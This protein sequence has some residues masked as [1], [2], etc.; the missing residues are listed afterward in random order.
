MPERH[1]RLT[2][3]YFQKPINAHSIARL[4]A[5][6][7]CPPA[8]VA[9]LASTKRLL[10]GHGLTGPAMPSANVCN[11]NTP[12]SSPF[13]NTQNP[14]NPY[15]RISPTTVIVLHHS[16]PSSI[17]HFSW[18]PTVILWLLTWGNDEDLHPHHNIAIVNMRISPAQ[19]FCSPAARI[20]MYEVRFQS[21]FLV[22]SASMSVAS[23]H[24]LTVSALFL[25]DCGTIADL[26]VPHV[27]LM[28]DLSSFLFLFG[29][30]R[31]LFL[32]FVIV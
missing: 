30:L 7:S 18:H 20:F 21:C 8:P 12:P 15:C 24:I 26:Y 19:S 16:P 5:H 22:H 13:P 4:H 17:L 3:S 2:A 32:A 28:P 1:R 29:L 31:M 23:K 10:M 6:G 14:Q 11:H 9:C 25:F 27:V